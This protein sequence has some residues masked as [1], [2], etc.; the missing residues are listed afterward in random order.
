MRR[1]VAA[2]GPAAA[3]PLLPENRVKLK[4]ARDFQWIADG[5]IQRFFRT[6]AQTDFLNAK[7]GYSGE[8]YRFQHGMLTPA[9]NLRFQQRL[10]GCSK[11]LPSCTR[12]ASL[13]RPRSALAPACSSPCG[14]GNWRLRGLAPHGR[15]ARRS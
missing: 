12:T 9:A 10:G 8:I 11:S 7:F 13:R 5:P 6:Q 3:H 2:P 4:I 15:T 14:P 1:P